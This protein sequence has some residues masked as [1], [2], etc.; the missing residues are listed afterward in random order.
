M[1][2]AA[3]PVRT[4]ET[5]A[6]VRSSRFCS[7]SS[8]RPLSLPLIVYIRGN[9]RR[10]ALVARSIAQ[11]RRLD[12]TAALQRCILWAG[13][14]RHG[15]ATIPPRSRRKSIPGSW[16]KVGRDREES[17]SLRLFSRLIGHVALQPFESLSSILGCG[18][19][20]FRIEP[21]ERLPARVNAAPRCITFRREGFRKVGGF[22]ECLWNVYCIQQVDPHW[23]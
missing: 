14:A 23:K 13:C 17:L 20:V 22:L 10:R 9:T 15:T 6:P 4:A 3:R 8:A 12:S 18:A 11:M 2:P 5:F 1:E 21:A 16:I 7:N 19:S